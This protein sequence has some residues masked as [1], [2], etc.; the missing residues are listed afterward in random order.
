MNLLKSIC[1]GAAIISLATVASSAADRG[2]VAGNFGIELDGVKAGF[3]RSV[4]GGHVSS[5]VVNETTGLDYVT[6]KHLAGVKYGDVVVQLP[7]NPSKP[8]CDWISG[9]FDRNYQRKNGAIIAADYR[10]DERQRLSF[11]GALLTEISIPA[12]DAAS[13]DPAYM[14][15]KISPENLKWEGGKGKLLGDSKGSQKLWLPSNFRLDLPGLDCTKVQ[16]IDAFTIKQS[17]AENSL[18]AERDYVTEP[19][20]L[21]IPNLRVTLAATTAGS[22]LDWADKFIIKGNN[23]ENNEKTGTLTLL[24]PNRSEELVRVSLYQ[25]GIYRV[26]RP[27]GDNGDKINTVTVELYVERMEIDFMAQFEK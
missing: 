21:E 4:E 1:S 22:W 23:D 3:L 26:E 12:C 20:K 14:S 25:V 8:I 5:D 24:S 16:K 15:L 18:G 6:K 13:K 2:Y 17:V 9:T 19:S 7:V 11:Q 27:F 10:L